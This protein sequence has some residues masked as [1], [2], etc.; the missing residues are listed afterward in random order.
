MYN[1]VISFIQSIASKP[2][3]WFV[4]NQQLLQWIK[5]PVKASELGNQPYM[6]CTKP[7]IPKEICNGLDDD[8]NGTIDDGLINSCN[9][10]ATV[11]NTCFNC[12]SSAP[13]LTNPTP[14]T[15]AQNGT[16]GFRYPNPETCDTTWWD[17]IG[18]ACLCTSADC[19]VKS[20]AVNRTSSST[21]PNGSNSTTANGNSSTKGSDASRLVRNIASTAVAAAVLAGLQQFI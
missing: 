1:G 19:Q 16:A 14:A 12:P 15:S 20:I 4:T 5:N 3:V 21:S 11:M 2:N 6:Q 10:N 9:F 13:T 18:N 8:H 7:V 17:P